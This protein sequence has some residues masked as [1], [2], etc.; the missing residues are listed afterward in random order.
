MFR[1]RVFFP[2]LYFSKLYLRYYFIYFELKSS[3]LG[4]IA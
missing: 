1:K 4:I 3:T 2:K